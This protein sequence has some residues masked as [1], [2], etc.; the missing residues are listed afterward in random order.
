[1]K[2]VSSQWSGV[3]KSVFFFTLCT[4]L[5]AL[6]DPAE[7]QQTR[8]Y[9]I[10]FLRG[11]RPLNSHVEVFR[12]SLKELGYVDG[13]NATIEYRWPEGKVDQLPV[14]AAELI[15]LKVDVIVADG[16]RPTQAAKAAS[17]TIPIVMQSGNPIELGFVS[18][19]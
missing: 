2:V 13:K 9:R 17:N 3:S 6:S 10:G 8:V 7:A 14:L 11:A 1:M 4:I 16:S 15:G 19:L 5:F 12:H 18:S